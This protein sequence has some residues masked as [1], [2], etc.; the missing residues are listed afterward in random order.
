MYRNDFWRCRNDF[1]CRTRRFVHFSMSAVFFSPVGVRTTSLELFLRRRWRRRFTK[2]HRDI[3][4]N[5]RLVQYYVNEN[6]GFLRMTVYDSMRTHP[7]NKTA[8][9]IQ[10]WTRGWLQRLDN[11][12][13]FEH[14]MTLINYAE[15]NGA[16]QPQLRHFN[17]QFLTR[18][19]V[20]A[21]RPRFYSYDFNV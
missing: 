15:S 1:W 14:L 12:R 13:R 10:R 20:H 18:R 3:N 2:A 16:H 11:Q 7:A 8:T 9:T 19:R 4:N 5:Y 6:K 17:A 21:V